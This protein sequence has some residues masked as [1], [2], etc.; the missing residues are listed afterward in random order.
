MTG[1]QKICPVCGKAYKTRYPGQK[2]CSRSCG[3]RYTQIALRDRTWINSEDI[4][5]T[6]IYLIHKW[7]A[8]G[9]PEQEISSA[10]G[11]PEKEIRK[12]QAIPE[13]EQERALIAAYY[14]P[15]R[16]RTGKENNESSGV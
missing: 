13:T 12:I 15:Y 14:S 1:S 9:M 16:M 5:W 4:S 7:T 11:R 6:T 3:S 8:E 2:T 10:L